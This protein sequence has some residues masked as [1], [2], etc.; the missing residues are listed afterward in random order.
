MSSSAEL[1]FAVDVNTPLSR[2]ELQVLRI[3]Y[4]KEEQ[5]GHTSVQTKFNLAWGLVKSKEREEVTEG[6]ALLSEIYKQEAER[7]RECLYYL[8]LGNYKVSNYAD[9][10][11]L[12]DVLLEKEPNNLQ[13]RSLGQI[14]DKAWAK[15]GF[16]RA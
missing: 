14:I 8:A 16:G 7:R 12:N 6:V 3:Q 15:G 2:S 9:A 10:K 13:A 4:D 5:A 1:P 11:R